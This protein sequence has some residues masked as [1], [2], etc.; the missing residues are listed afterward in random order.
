[1]RRFLCLALLAAALPASAFAAPAAIPAPVPAPAAAPGAAQAPAIVAMATFMSE[2]TGAVEVQLGGSD[3]WKRAKV[4]EALPPGTTIKTAANSNCTIVFADRS[5]VRLD[6]N[7]SLKLEELS[8]AKVQVFLPL[9]RVDAWVKKLAGRAFQIRTPSATAAV[10][11]TVLR[12]ETDATGTRTYVFDGVVVSQ[13]MLGQVLTAHA[14]QTITV[15]IAAAPPPPPPPAPGAPPAPPPP[16]PAIQME[17]VLTPVAIQ[18][19]QEPVIN[20]INL[21]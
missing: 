3:I 1:M 13:N 21:L 18:A 12:I 11:G 16:P 4:G 20:I 17:V 6:S 9:G 7:S 19:L 8:N 10:R 5:Q 14:G 2:M 15:Q